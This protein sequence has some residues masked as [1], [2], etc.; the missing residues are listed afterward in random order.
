LVT[1]VVVFGTLTSPARAQ[2]PVPANEVPIEENP[3]EFSGYVQPELRYERNGGDDEFYF[4]L[5]RGRLKMEYELDPASF[6]L[7]IDATQ[8]GVDI[9]EIWGRIALPL[10]A[11]TELALIAGLFK[12]PFGF[13]LQVS[14]SRRVFPERSQMVRNLFPG[15]RDVGLRLDGSFADELIVAQLAV[16]NGLPIGD[17]H[18]GAFAEPDGDVYKDVTLR[19]AVEPGPVTVGVSGLY[20]RGTRFVEDDPMTPAVVEAPYDFPRWAVGGEARLVLDVPSLGELDFSGELAFARNLARDR[21]ADYPQTEDANVDVLAWYVA[22]VQ[23][24]GEYFALGARFDQY[25]VEDDDPSNV[26]TAVGMALPADGVRVVLAYDFHL[27]DDGGANEG[28]LRMQV[29]W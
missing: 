9:K 28:W 11:G 19:V 4:Q 17:A 27:G 13:D 10:P 25:R 12:I 29:K 5:R 3:L 18:F 20:G 7:E 21:D 14:S 24:L 8:D 6:L 16:Q 23:S 2:E 26:I 15:E 22:A 1:V